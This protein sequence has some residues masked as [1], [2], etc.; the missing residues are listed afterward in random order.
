MD[1]TCTLCLD[2]PYKGGMYC[3]GCGAMGRPHPHSAALA[4]ALLSA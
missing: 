2:I 4:D 3:D 1:S